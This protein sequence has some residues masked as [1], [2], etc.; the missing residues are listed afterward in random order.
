[1]PRSRCLFLMPVLFCLALLPATDA[2]AQLESPSP[3]QEVDPD[4]ADTAEEA[5]E[6]EDAPSPSE[7]GAQARK[8]TEKA[9]DGAEK[10]KDAAAASDVVPAKGTLPAEPAA[11]ARSK[12]PALG[13][14]QVSNAD[15]L[16]LWK[17]WQTAAAAK[18]TAGADTAL[19][20]LLKRKEEVEASD[21]EPISVGLLRAAAERRQGGDVGGAMLLTEAAVTV[22][23]NLPYVRLAYAE[24]LARREPGE[25][26]RYLGEVKR[27]LQSMAGDVRY[28]RPALADLGTVGVFALWM[29][30]VAVVGVLFVRRVRYLLHDLHHFFPRVVDRWQSAVL[31]LL[32][33]STPLVLRM[34]LLPVLLVLLGA[35]TLYLTVAERAVAWGL[36]A[37]VGFSPLV[38]GGLARATA[39]AGTVA[40][41]VYVLER[42]GFAADEAAARVRARHA[43]RAVTF[44]ELFALGRYEARRG[45]LTEAVAHYKAA[46][47][48]RNGDARLLTNW[49]N[50]LLA[51]GSLDGAVQ[52]YTDATRAGTPLPAP[53]YNLAMVYRRKAKLV[54]DEEVSGVLHLAR[55]AIGT[56]Q[57]LDPALI[58][59]EPPPED[60]TLVSRL[61]LSLPLPQ[62]ELA[63]L[64]ADEAAGER[65]RAQLSRV[66]MAGMTGPLAWGLPFALG[67]LLFGF[68]FLRQGL[69]A[70]KVCEKCG[71]AACRRCDPDLGLGSTLCTQCVNVFS[72]KGLVPPQ[73][74]ARKQAQVDRYQTWM[75]RVA[76]ALGALVSGAGHV[77][78]GLPLRGALYTFLFLLGVGTVFFH[79]GVLRAPYGEAPSYL[80]FTLAG[81]LLLP[82]YLLTW[83][84]LYR[85][86]N[87]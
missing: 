12:L 15:L 55:E 53:F 63:E 87:G 21:L 34:G 25:V 75:G 80:K 45:Q 51:T 20:E 73:L 46:S 26:G 76:L 1:M 19:R 56:A 9:K 59:R 38:A 4:V 2:V 78:A 70:S 14:P 40:E 79:H 54:S 42:G 49:G 68:G 6:P 82:V 11:P 17:R 16:A 18:D 47:V 43:A 7:E 3:I 13:T 28:L 41:D 35:V 65:V 52:L 39:F 23:P 61:V 60:N 44:Q 31:V 62:S 77:F 72:R 36:L 27:A 66:L 67:G 71:R 29:T 58:Q 69:K 57:D 84:G 74:K 85:R 83:R 81:L 33:L 22:S 37:L 24:A 86:Q 50:A 48:L 10:P 5:D 30:A 8:A 64:G 32:L